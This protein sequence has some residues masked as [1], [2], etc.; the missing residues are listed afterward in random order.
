[1]FQFFQSCQ[2]IK[3][4]T[5]EFRRY[6]Q[7]KEDIYSVLGKGTTRNLWDITE[8][9]YWNTYFSMPNIKVSFILH[10]EANGEGLGA[11]LYQVQEGKRSAKLDGTI[12][13]WMAALPNYTFSMTYKPARNNWDA[14]A[15]SRIQWPEVMVMNSQTVKAGCENVQTYHGNDSNISQILEAI[16]NKTI[17]KWKLKSDMDFDLKCL[18]RGNNWKLGKVFCIEEPYR[19]TTRGSLNSSD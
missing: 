17:G 1:M 8:I 14:D 9:V 3:S 7:S 12:H 19:S 18:M 13:R 16:H 10:I 11:V 2:T 4:N 15:L 5:L 6:I